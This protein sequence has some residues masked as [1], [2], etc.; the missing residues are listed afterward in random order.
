M[1][2]PSLSVAVVCGL[3]QVA[4]GAL[5][6]R[7]LKLLPASVEVNENSGVE[8]SVVDPSAGPAVIDV[9]GGVVSGGPVIVKPRVAGEGSVLPAASIARTE[10]MWPP[11][12]SVGVYPLEQVA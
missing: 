1:C 10:K 6:T 2:D 9:S 7:H 12:P 8:S 3:V 5:S 4:N 11:V